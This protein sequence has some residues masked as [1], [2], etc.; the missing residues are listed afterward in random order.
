MQGQKLKNVLAENVLA[1]SAKTS[2]ERWMN[3]RPKLC[4]KCQK[5]KNPRGG[6]LRIAAGLHKFICKDCMDA[7]AKNDTAST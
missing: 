4:W 3:K 6:Y 5:E 7:K 2:N 1:M